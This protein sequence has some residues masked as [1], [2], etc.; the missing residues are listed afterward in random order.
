M[1]LLQTLNLHIKIRTKKK[2]DSNILRQDY[3][4]ALATD[5]Y[6]VSEVQ[7][8]SVVAETVCTNITE[9]KTMDLLVN[10]K[11]NTI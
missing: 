4:D 1:G 10:I 5:L 11:R 2:K 9:L 8:K 3:Q 7:V 6:T